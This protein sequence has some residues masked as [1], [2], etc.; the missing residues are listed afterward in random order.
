MKKYCIAALLLAGTMIIP[1]LA[2]TPPA[3]GK[4]SETDDCRNKKRPDQPIAPQ[5]SQRHSPAERESNRRFRNGPGMWMVF[6]R[7]TPEERREMEKLQREDPE[8]FYE[9][10]RQKADE[11]F[12]KREARREELR[13]LAERCRNAATPEERERL[14]KQLK[15]EVEKDFRDHLKANRRQLEDMKRRTEHLEKELQ[16][17]E[18]NIDKAVDVHVDALIQGKKP[19]RRADSRR[20]GRKPLEK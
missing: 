11:L 9:L 7:L 10:M 14:K 15:E 1:A 16:R 12:R 6:S 19:P 20:F 4:P 18:K 3:N 13:K 17:R 5:T 8:R 2:A